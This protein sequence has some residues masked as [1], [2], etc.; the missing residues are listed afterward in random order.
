MDELVALLAQ[1]ASRHS[2]LCPRQVLGVRIGMYASRLLELELPREDK[3]VLTFVETDGCFA[4]GIAVSTGCWL[5]RRTLRLMDYGKVAATIVDTQTGR[6]VRIWPSVAARSRAREYAPDAPTPWQ[7][8][9]LGYQVMPANEL[10]RSREVS[11]TVSLDALI[12]RP[13]ARAACATCGEEVSNEREVSVGGRTTCRSCA[14]DAYY[15]L[16]A[17]VSPVPHS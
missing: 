8:Y 1:T 14:G 16:P 11:L 12:S 5:G 15:D 6:A 7:A 9:L 17:L 10:L 2:G 13:G 3:R 4:D